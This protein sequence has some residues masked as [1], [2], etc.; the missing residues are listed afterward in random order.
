MWPYRKKSKTAVEAI[1]FEGSLYSARQI[2][3]WLDNPETGWFSNDL[4]ELLVPTSNGRE[5]VYE[6]DWVTR[7]AAGFH[8]CTK[9]VFARSHT[10]VKPPFK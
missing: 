5:A 9:E 2:L 3:A 7:D 6:D 4:E 8:V 10:A 1:K